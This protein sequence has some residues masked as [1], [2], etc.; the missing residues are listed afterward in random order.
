MYDKPNTIEAYL[1]VGRMISIRLNEELEKQLKEVASFEGK[2]V[3][4]FVRQIIC[5]RLEDVYDAKIGE[6]AYKE[7]IETGKKSYDYDEVFKN[8]ASHNFT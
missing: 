1:E 3:S 4:D 7:Y 8:N 5:E 6:E 2:S